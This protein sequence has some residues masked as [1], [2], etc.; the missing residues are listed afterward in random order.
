VRSARSLLGEIVHVNEFNYNAG[1]SGEYE[2]ADL[3][4]PAGWKANRIF[5][6]NGNINSLELKRDGYQLFK[7]T[8]AENDLLQDDGIRVPQSG[9]F[10]VDPSEEGYGA[11]P[12]VIER[13]QVSDFRIIADLSSSG[14]IP[15]TMEYLGP[16]RT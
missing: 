9:L 5:I 13:S 10:V 12:L 16:F 4:R 6:W 3:P 1:A 15:V 2:I 7:R 8:P 11:D 14:A